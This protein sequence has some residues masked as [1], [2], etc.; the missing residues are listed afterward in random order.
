MKMMLCR[1][2]VADY[3]KWRT[4]FDSHATAHVEAGLRLVDLWRDIDDPN[5][6]FFLFE[7]VDMDRTVAF[8]SDPAAVEA[9]ERSGVIEGEIHWL[10]SW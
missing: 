7:V 6:V 5:N 10:E 1:N 4:V 9:G 2:R 3:T 8:V